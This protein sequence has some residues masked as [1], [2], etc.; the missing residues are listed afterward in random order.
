M[1]ERWSAGG[2]TRVEFKIRKS[3]ARTLLVRRHTRLRSP[4]P[5]L[6]RQPM[7][8]VLRAGRGII[9]DLRLGARPLLGPGGG[10]KSGL[11]C[12]PKSLWGKLGRPTDRHGAARNT[13]ARAVACSRR[14]DYV[15][16][17]AKPSTR[18][19]RKFRTAGPSLQ[20]QATHAVRERKQPDDS[21]QTNKQM[22]REHTQS[23]VAVGD[24][25]TTSCGPAAPAARRTSP[26][27]R[28]PPPLLPPPPRALRR[29]SPRR[30]RARRPVSS[31]GPRPRP[32]R[33]AHNQ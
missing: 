22:L 15:C 24:A 29:P 18:R 16:G 20:V 9:V 7:A 1:L 11:G 6:Q 30:W 33:L 3:G 23:C 14:D 31:P 2:C 21:R 32:N 4:W 25:P 28:T 26:P 8:V 12:L 27:P 19:A 5:L 17:V 10:H 13:S